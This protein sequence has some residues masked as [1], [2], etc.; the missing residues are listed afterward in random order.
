M[1]STISFLEDCLQQLQNNCFKYREA[2]LIMA[3]SWISR[4][5]CSKSLPSEARPVLM[6]RCQ[7]RFAQALIILDACM[8]EDK[9]VLNLLRTQRKMLNFALECD[10]VN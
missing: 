9:F 4:A 2:L 5:H 8:T 1:P 7:E 6:K 3:L 10:A